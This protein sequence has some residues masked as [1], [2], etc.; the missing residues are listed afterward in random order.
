MDSW[1]HG[2]FGWGK[3][4]FL[5][6]LAAIWTMAFNSIFFLRLPMV[7]THG[8]FFCPEISCNVGPPVMLVGL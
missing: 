3:R 4:G 8:D 5:K 7:I 2:D 1:T 6:L